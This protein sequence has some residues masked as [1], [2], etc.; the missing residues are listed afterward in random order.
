MTENV[1]A[2]KVEYVI[3]GQRLS[4]SDRE[5]TDRG[6]DVAAGGTAWMQRTSIWVPMQARVRDRQGL[7][8]RPA[9]RRQ[10]SQAI[11]SLMTRP[12]SF[13]RP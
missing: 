1:G 2:S 4:Y 5:S 9:F 12:R 3:G 6:S 11:F 13:G 10:Q 7:T 8:P